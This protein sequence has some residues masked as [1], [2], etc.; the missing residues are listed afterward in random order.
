[1]WQSSDNL[2]FWHDKCIYQ[3]CGSFVTKRNY[4]DD[5]DHMIKLS[6]EHKGIGVRPAPVNSFIQSAVAILCETHIQ[7]TE[8]IVSWMRKEVRSISIILLILWTEFSRKQGVVVKLLLVLGH[9]W[10][11]GNTE[12]YVIFIFLWFI[13]VL[14]TNNFSHTFRLSSFPIL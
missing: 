13:I 11:I 7:A 9:W 14:G 12:L 3:I 6:N 2:V 5:L 1:M 10:Y 8:T 4:V